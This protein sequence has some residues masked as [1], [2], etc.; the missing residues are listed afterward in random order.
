MGRESFVFATGGLGNQLFQVASALG[1]GSDVIRI[2]PNITNARKNTHGKLDIEDFNFGQRVIFDRKISLW[3]VSQKGIN[4]TLRYFASKS[5]EAPRTLFSQLILFATS[6]LLSMN[7]HRRIWV[8]ANR[9]LGFDPKILQNRRDRFY[10]G[11]FQ[12]FNIL[13]NQQV[14]SAMRSLTLK[15]DSDIVKEYKR[16]ANFESPLIVHVRMGDYKESEQFGVLPEGYYQEAIEHLWEQESYKRIWLFS[17][18]PESAISRIPERLKDFVRV[19]PEFE[20]STPITFEVMRLGTGYVIAN[21]SFSWWAASLAHDPEAKIAAPDVWFK[22]STSPD[23]ILPSHWIK[24][25]AWK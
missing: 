12:T 18:E 3:K 2:I 13:L 14:N 7:I 16:Y 21:S 25:N 5:I 8:L 9:G 19:I 1:S 24:F 20:K 22:K 23:Q 6:T 11:Y 15:N 17:D 4:Y 10:I